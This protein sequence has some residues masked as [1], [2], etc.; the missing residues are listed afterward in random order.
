MDNTGF[1]V[2]AT[3]IHQLSAPQDAGEPLE[4]R[5]SGRYASVHQA[6]RLARRLRR[7]LAV[8]AKKAVVTVIEIVDAS[9]GTVVWRE[10][11]AAR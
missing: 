1:F 2:C 9:V 8:R 7:R 10:T 4:R 5:V 11:V 3:F 6:A